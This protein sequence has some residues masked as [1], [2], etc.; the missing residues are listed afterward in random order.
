MP[1]GSDTKA[2]VRPGCTGPSGR[3][4]GPKNAGGAD[5]SADLVAAQRAQET[6]RRYRGPLLRLPNVVGV[7]VGFKSVQGE[8]S[9]IPAIVVMVSKKFP[10][11]ELAGGGLV[12]CELDGV[13]TDVVEMGEIKAF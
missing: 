9:R 2:A 3:A 12:P 4:G 6:A 13:P 11:V 1:E 10:P 7:G 8:R 5:S